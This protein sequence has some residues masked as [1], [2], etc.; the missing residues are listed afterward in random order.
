LQNTNIALGDFAGVVQQIQTLLAMLTHLGLEVITTMKKRTFII[1]NQ[2]I[3][4]TIGE[5]L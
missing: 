4:T 1:F 2:G 3:T 5:D